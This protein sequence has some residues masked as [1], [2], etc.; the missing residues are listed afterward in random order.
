MQSQEMQQNLNFRIRKLLQSLTWQDPSIQQI[1]GTSTL[2]SVLQEKLSQV[3]A[4]NVSPIPELSSLTRKDTLTAEELYHMCGPFFLIF[5]P[6]Y[7]ETIS[8]HNY[9][10]E[11]MF[12]K[13]TPDIP[14][15]MRIVADVFEDDVLL[16]HRAEINFW[17][18]NLNSPKVRFVSVDYWEPHPMPKYEHIHWFAKL[19][20]SLATVWNRY[21][22]PI[23]ALTTRQGGETDET[24]S[25]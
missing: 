22:S 4:G 19:A 11:F 3:Q 7:E 25:A 16:M 8:Y 5:G 21:S 13:T 6:T 1:P 2:L 12:Q 15:V 14:T 23:P 20:H 24:V 17:K 18:E 9:R 10:I